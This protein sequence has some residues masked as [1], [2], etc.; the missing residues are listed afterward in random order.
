MSMIVERPLQDLYEKAYRRCSLPLVC[1]SVA[2]W[3][4]V[5]SAKSWSAEDELKSEQ[6]SGKARGYYSFWLQGVNLRNTT[7]IV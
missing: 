3:L 1:G 7:V 2:T 4:E 5:S 6:W